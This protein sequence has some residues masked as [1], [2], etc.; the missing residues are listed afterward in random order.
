MAH[1]M[2]HSD[3]QEVSR[4]IF[5]GRGKLIVVGVMIVG[6]LTY[7][8]F[9]AFQGSTT[10][11]LTVDELLN[12]GSTAYDQQMRVNGKMVPGSFH[13][14]D[15]STIS[16]FVLT[17]DGGVGR[18]PTTYEGVVPDLFFNEHTQIVA[19]GQY[20]TDG[21]FHANNIIVKCPS[22]YSSIDGST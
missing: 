19:E 10:Y 8:A 1:L 18:L 6:A 17:Q 15:G 3:G 14:Q 22:K 4:S 9:V 2:N 21:V 5:R 13:R 11:Y 16:T 7:F 12:Q 20:R